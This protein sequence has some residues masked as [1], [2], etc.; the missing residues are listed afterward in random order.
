MAAG[1]AAHAQSEKEAVQI[2]A[3][4]SHTCA[5]TTDG[6]IWCWGGNYSGQLGAGGWEA[7]LAREVA[8]LA[9]LQSIGVGSSHTCA[10]TD[11]GEVRCWGDNRDGQLG[12]G[13][14]QIAAFPRVVSGLD[15]KVV[16]VRGSCALTRSDRVLCWGVRY[17]TDCTGGWWSP[18]VCTSRAVPHGP[19]VSSLGP[20]SAFGNC[21]LTAPGKV[22]C[23][24][25]TTQRA[26]DV[27]PSEIVAETY[28]CTLRGSGALTC[29]GSNS[30]GQVGIG[31]T[32]WVP[33]PQAPRIPGTA[34]AIVGG[35]RHTCA[36]QTDGQVYCWGMNLYGQTGT[37]GSN[38][39]S[40][41]P[42]EGAVIAITGGNEH[43]C[44]LTA[45]RGVK[46]WGAKALVGNGTFTQQWGPVDVTGFK[47]AEVNHQGLWWNAPAGSESGWG[48][49][50]EQQG[51]SLFAV[52]Y[53]Y[54][55][56]GRGM[57]LV[58]PSAMRRVDGSYFGVLYRTTG[59]RF[60]AQPWDP[61]QVAVSG[62]GGA[63]LH[64]T[65]ANN[66]TM[67]YSIGDFRDSRMITRQ[68]FGATLPHCAEGAVASGGNYQGLWWASPPGSE[69]G[70]GVS[71]AQQ[72][73]MLF[74]TWFTYDLAGNGRWLVMSRGERT[75]PGRYSGAL[76]ET[77]G[78][79]LGAPWNAQAFSSTVV[80]NASFGF[81]DAQNG[82][83]TYTLDGVTQTKPI[84]RQVFSTPRTVCQ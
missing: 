15:E 80:G 45:R 40:R 65:D 16:A 62:V 57:W 42:I 9:G 71:I 75:A 1:I 61:A 43:T 77:R 48:L 76:H 49:Q 83:F 64:F 8:G 53:T 44:V 14:T 32:A 12:D 37:G 33:G 60:D 51:G 34:M 74:A 30:Y 22:L 25:G 3:G 79:P 66:G 19:E 78:S 84:T 70:W 81:S 72:G 17:E 11:D 28:S 58:L 23:W 55:S 21:Q 35:D 39:P 63:V 29:E 50:I 26:F 41:V 52:W 59:P 54:G 56:D 46:C 13:T 18:I 67:Y 69:A 24:A 7:S 2:A 82:S 20:R 10:V 36:L 68:Q 5:L 73:D 38:W 4:R 31:T 6:R 27:G 47:G